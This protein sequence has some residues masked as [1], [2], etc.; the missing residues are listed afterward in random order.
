VDARD[1]TLS[2]KEPPVSYEKRKVLVVDDDPSVQEVVR[3]YLERDGFVVWVAGNGAEAVRLAAKMKPSL[4]VLDLMLPDVPGE[5]LARRI[6]ARSDVPI[7]MLTA[8]ASEDERVAGLK[9]GADDYLTK[10][11]S[12]RELAGRVRAIL[13]RTRG[14]TTPLVDVAL[15]GDGRLEVDTL[16]HEV[17]RDGMAVELTPN[18][19]K[20]LAAL[21][22]YPGRVYSRS[23]LLNELQGLEQRGFERTVDA[24][25]KNLRKKIEPDP[26]RPRYVQTVFGVGYRLAK[27]S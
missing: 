25:V 12:P 24:H 7:L 21:A 26:R 4:I 10:P 22:R 16:R 20:L 14:D 3:A 11:F 15:L 19:F 1:C 8:K 13:R 6:R 9:L 5:E 2:G 27:G 23:E 17:R 18:E